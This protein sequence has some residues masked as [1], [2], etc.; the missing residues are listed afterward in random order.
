M[1][2]G[3]KA[4]TVV[5]R[6]HRRVASARSQAHGCN[7]HSFGVSEAPLDAGG[8]QDEVEHPLARSSYCRP[9]S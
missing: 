4:D 3:R 5:V 6:S 9:R 7:Q 2:G 8:G 1:P